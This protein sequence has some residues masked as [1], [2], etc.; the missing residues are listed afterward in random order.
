MNYAKLPNGLLLSDV[1]TILIEKPELLPTTAA[2]KVEFLLELLRMDEE[3]HNS[4]PWYR[5]IFNKR[6]FTEEDI[7][8]LLGVVK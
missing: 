7:I 4:L 6:L 3:Y 1:Y 8:K 5:R 2:G